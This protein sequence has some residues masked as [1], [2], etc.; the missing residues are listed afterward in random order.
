MAFS[1]GVG[2]FTEGL[3]GYLDCF[4]ACVVNSWLSEPWNWFSNKVHKIMSHRNQNWK[5][6]LFSSFLNHGKE[7]PFFLEFSYLRSLSY[8]YTT[9]A[10]D[11]F[12]GLV[13]IWEK[14]KSRLIFTGCPPCSGLYVRCSAMKGGITGIIQLTNG[15][16][17]CHSHRLH[18]V[19]STGSKLWR[20]IVLS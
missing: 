11:N 20:V 15:W 9:V 12:I 3:L 2:Q 7:W 5:I 19:I 18:S 10:I 17:V 13:N 1:G 4:V 8:V 6:M 14:K 16:L